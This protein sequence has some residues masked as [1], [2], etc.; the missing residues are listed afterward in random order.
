MLAKFTKL[1]DKTKY[2]IETI[3][4][5]KMINTINIL[6]K[7]ILNQMIM[8]LNKILKLHMLIVIIRSAFKEDAKYYSQVF[9]YLYEL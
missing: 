5:D 1:W 6:W 9:V 7:L 2:L 8:S 3:G 4:R